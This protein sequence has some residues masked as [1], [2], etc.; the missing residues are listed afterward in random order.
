[1]K[2]IVACCTLLFAVC[3]WADDQATVTFSGKGKGGIEVRDASGKVEI[4]NPSTLRLNQIPADA[5]ARERQYREKVEAEATALA[6]QRAE[7]AAGAELSAKEAADADAAAHAEQI[8]AAQKAEELEEQQH[9]R[10]LRRSTVRG[11]RYVENPPEPKPA[12]APES[13]EPVLSISGKKKA[14]PA[15][16]APEAPANDSAKRTSE[17]EAPENPEGF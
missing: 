4:V 2:T 7:E 12:P 8:A 15:A 14:A 1:M 3:A 13:A 16:D 10:K 17:A 6:A 9:P 11:T 5:A